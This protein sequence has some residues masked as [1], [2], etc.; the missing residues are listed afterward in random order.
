M[1][2]AGGIPGLAP[3]V[4]GPIRSRGSTAPRAPL[5]LMLGVLLGAA[6]PAFAQVPSPAQD[7]SP[8][9]QAVQQNPGLPDMIHQ[10]LQHSGFTP[11]QLRARLSADG[12]AALLPRG[13]LVTTGPGT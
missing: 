13:A 8:L 6:T 4:S 12:L 3:G 10:R 1:T 11:G 9:Q 2:T 5:A 7:R